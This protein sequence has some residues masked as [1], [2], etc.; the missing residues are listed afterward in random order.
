MNLLALPRVIADVSRVIWTHPANRGRRL[1]T[2]CRFVAWQ[3]NKRLIRSVW[4]ISAFEQF[5]MR[6]HPDS[7]G[8]IAMIYTSGCPDYE[9]MH[10]VQRYLKTGDAVVDIGANIGIYSLLF[11]RCVGRTGHVLAFEAGEQA[12][13]YFKENIQ[14]NQLQTLIDAR[15]SAIG[16]VDGTVEFI[17]SA[18]V[19]NRL[20][21]QSQDHQ[22][23]V[24]SVP[25][26]TLDTALEGRPFALGKIDIEGTEPMIFRQAKQT[27]QQANPPV[28]LIELKDRLLQKFG[29]SADE[30]ASFLR[31][32]GFQLA[33]YD[34]TT[35]ELA[36]S[37]KPWTETG[38]VIAV[39]ESHID[40]TRQRLAASPSA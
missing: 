37:E 17:Q 9:E 4:T 27:L 16:E 35:N 13:Q 25:C 31:S 14:L 32:H 24:R 38:N 2:A 29:F 19:V 21:V 18:D 23:Q 30:F 33:T 3:F 28:W 26:V 15:Y 12:Y 8:S 7:F 20:A 10:F 36:F 22:Q 1:K 11:A 5:Q 39:H 40:A 34:P 6:L